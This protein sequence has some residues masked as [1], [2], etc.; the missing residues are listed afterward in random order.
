[1]V[2]DFIYFLF[3]DWRIWCWILLVI[4]SMRGTIVSMMTLLYTLVTDL[5]HVHFT[6]FSI[7]SGDY[8]MGFYW[9]NCQLHTKFGP[10]NFNNQ[11]TTFLMDL[12]EPFQVSGR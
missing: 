8:G 7:F 6:L 2:A 4:F 10:T 5:H 12:R 11:W 3:V 1:M 9:R